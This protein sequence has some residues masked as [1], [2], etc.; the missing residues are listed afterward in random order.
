MVN[1]TSESTT[2]GALGTTHGSCLPFGL[3]VTSL[4]S[5]STV[6]CSLSKVAMGLN[7]TLK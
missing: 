1:A 2:G 4:L 3:I 7:A 5:L 6:F